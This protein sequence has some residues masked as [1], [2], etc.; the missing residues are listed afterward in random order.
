M[1]SP[2]RYFV[3][4]RQSVPEASGVTFV[5]VVALAICLA[6]VVRACGGEFIYGLDDPYTHLTVAK[7]IL[8]GEYG[9]N[10]GEFSSPSSSIIWP[11]LLVPFVLVGAAEAGP[12]ILGAAFSMAVALLTFRLLRQWG[13]Y[14]SSQASVW[15]LVI[16]LVTFQLALPFYGMEHSLHAACCVAILLT[17]PSV[18]LDGASPRTL[19]WA[20]FVGAATR[21]EGV[22]IG[23][24]AAGMLACNRQFRETL[25]V[26]AATL[27]PVAG[28]AAFLYWIG[29]PALPDSILAKQSVPVGIRLSAL[30]G[31][32]LILV[33]VAAAAVM[34][35]RAWRRWPHLDRQDRGAHLALALGA[36]AAAGHLGVGLFLRR[37]EAYALLVLYVSLVAAS[38]R[39]L[40]RRDVALCFAMLLPFWAQNLWGTLHLA[41]AAQNIQSQHFEM[42]RFAREHLREPIAVNDIGVVSWRAEQPITDLWGLGSDA[43]RIAR[44]SG[45]AAWMSDFLPRGSSPRVAMIY[46]HWFQHLPQWWIRVGE[47]K[48]DGLRVTP[49]SDTVAIY[50]TDVSVVPHLRKAMNDA[51]VGAA[52][53][54][55]FVVMPSEAFDFPVSEVL[56]R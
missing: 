28:F 23:L 20:A 22:G 26:A 3:E 33:G 49:D 9:I 14:S 56:P 10:A 15:A 16:L 39:L 43:A 29:L 1:L 11:F 6:L 32:F 8:R 36:V 44:H 27:A 31:P 38:S 37:Y 7:S 30:S 24:A 52:R 17:L 35:V 4:S 54:A 46:D 48:L 2:A 5:W 40:T 45:D 25:V 34:G 55:R 21:Y 42:A 50:A 51:Q 19:A 13:D 53:D 12:L 18:M 47:L 41:R